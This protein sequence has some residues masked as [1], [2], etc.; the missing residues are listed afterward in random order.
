MCNCSKDE[1]CNGATSPSGKCDQEH[2][3][4]FRVGD[5]CTRPEYPGRTYV[6]RLIGE[7]EIVFENDRGDFILTKL[8]GYSHIGFNILPPK[9]TK[10]VPLWVWCHTDGGFYHGTNTETQYNGLSQKIR[11]QYLWQKIEFEVPL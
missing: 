1:T 2:R 3:T 11:D 8:N 6:V 4:I 9:R 10:T 5:V 7:H